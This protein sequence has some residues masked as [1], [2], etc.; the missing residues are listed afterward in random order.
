MSPPF[1]VN[2]LSGNRVRIAGRRYGEIVSVLYDGDRIVEFKVRM[3]D[4]GDVER[5][6]A[7]ACRIL[8]SNF[9]D[10]VD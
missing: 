3:D 7:G 5:F 2:H 6:L 4:T 9:H 1:R 10:P 8:L